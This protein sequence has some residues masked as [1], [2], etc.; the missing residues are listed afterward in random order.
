MARTA[1]SHIRNALTRV[2][3][4]QSIRARASALGVV[5][6][7]RKIDIVA[8]VYTLVLGSERGAVRTLASLRRSYEDDRNHTTLVRASPGSARL[9][10]GTLLAIQLGEV[11][12]SGVSA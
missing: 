11:R 5:K 6:R 8:L 9:C 1:E 3:S 2:L 7:R 4:P 10:H 12:R